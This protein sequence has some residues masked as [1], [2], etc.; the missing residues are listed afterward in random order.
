MGGLVPSGG[1]RGATTRIEIEGKNLKGARVFVGGRGVTMGVPQVSS[2]GDRIT[3]DVTVAPGALLGPHDVR[4]ATPKGVSDGARFWVDVLP[5]RPPEK[6]TAPATPQLLDGSVFSVINSRIPAKAGSD[7]FVFMAAA[8]E[9]WSFQCL[10][11][12][13]RSRMDPVLELTDSAGV[14]LRLAQGVW[15][16]NPR[17]FHRF[18]KS[19][20]YYL[21]VR[22]S[23][24]NGGPNYIYRLVAAKAPFVSGFAPRG[25]Q[26]GHQV[27]VA[28]Q[29][30]N[31]TSEH[32]SV[33]IPADAT[34][35]YWADVLAGSS[36]SY[37]LPLL[38]ASEPVQDGGDQ[39]SA[40]PLT[41]MPCSV[42]G[43]FHRTPVQKFSFAAAAG[44]KYVFDLIGRRIGSRIDGSLRVL[45]AS[46]KEVAANDDAPG[47]GKDARLEFACT[48]AGVYQVEV[49]NV[50]EI[51][52][53]DC[54]YRLRAYPV[55]PDFQ[56]SI[57]TDR[58]TVPSAGTVPLQVTLER[59]G[60][61]NGPVSLHCDGLPPGMTFG[62]GLIPAGKNS[63]EVTF[64]AP[65]EM[66][67]TTGSI[68]LLADAAIDGQTVTREAP[69][70]EKYEHRSIDLLLS[71]EYS[72][73]RPHHIWDML[74][75]GV[76]DR[77]DPITIT[78]TAGTLSL[79]PGGTVQIP[80]H[81]IRHPG[82]TGEVKVDTRGLPPKVTLTAVT[83][84]A[85]QTEGTIVLTAAPDAPPDIS[86]L[87][88]QAHLA[89]STALLRA[90]PLTISKK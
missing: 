72:Y 20:R 79:V 41:A 36:G 83:I 40:R 39:E 24:Y 13:L 35:V 90:L 14:G 87:I 71:V 31:L 26:P 65:P 84:A 82:A 63:V 38:V 45:D 67:F 44:R 11:D 66:P 49:R 33:A 18:A 10:A 29:G 76:T 5:N 3:A 74:L 15:E 46:G 69:G 42:D 7:R 55:V 17:F 19:G 57:A 12:D 52:G 75:V 32:V 80:I 43:I 1:P 61:F 2:G 70:W 58:V 89:N 78:S 73:T 4:I 51:T 21:T 68:R 8:G 30:V 56:V 59:L 34:G 48:T 25:G 86:S 47:L 9:V 16:S 23:E 50:E 53:P 60:G 37:V 81:V 27:E 77:T 22:D 62:G 28:L 6:S 54:F 64:T 88:V 85:N